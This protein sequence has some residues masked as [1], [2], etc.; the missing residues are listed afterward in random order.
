M[1]YAFSVPLLR[2]AMAV[3]IL[4]NFAFAGTMNVSII[5]LARNLT[6]S[7]VTLGVLLALVGVG[8]I[9]GGL[10]ASLLGRARRR[11]PIAMALWIVIALLIAAIPFAAGPAGNLAV[12]L[13]LAANL[14]IPAV[15]A[16]LGLIG[17]LLSLTDTMFLTIMQ[18]TIAP[19]YL[20]RVF[21]IQFLAGGILQPLSMV[22][23]GWAAALYGPGVTF[24]GGA[25]V[26]G[27]AIAIGISSRALREV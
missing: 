10:S 9:L 20:A 15:A 22:V 23:A 25:V 18:Q 16:L 27:L 11:G 17:L 19:D 26:L 6:P 24:V 7:P 21:S 13:P 5:V 1:R 14:R 3:T 8:G 12:W 4:G 2:T